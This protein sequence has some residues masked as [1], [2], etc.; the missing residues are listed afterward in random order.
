MVIRA[1]ITKRI[2]H[3]SDNNFSIYKVSLENGEEHVIT[4]YFPTLSEDLLYEFE[5]EEV[6]HP[7]FGLQY[8]ASK[9]K[10]ATEQNKV[11][12]ISYLSS[13]LFFG[14]GVVTATKIVNHLGDDAI[15]KILENKNVLREIGLN[16]LQTE[17]FYQALYENQTNE[18]ILVELYSYGLTT[19]LAMRLLNFYGYDVI[20]IIKENPYVLIEDIESIGFL[21]AD[22]IAFKLGFKENDQR[23]IEAAIIFSIKQYID[24]SGH[25]YLYENHLYKAIS[26][27]LNIN[28]LEKEIQDAIN[29]LIKNELI[30]KENNTYTLFEIKAIEENLAKY[31]LTFTK[32]ESTNINIDSLIETVEQT[33]YVDYT[34]QQKQAIIEAVNNPITVIT[35]GPGTGKTTVLLG[36]LR[37]YGLLNGLNLNSESIIETIG[38]CAPTGR[39]ARRMSEITGM[40]AFTIHRL[41]GYDYDKKFQYDEKN[42]LTQQLFI[43][44]EA[45]MIDIFLAEQLFKA[46]PEGA[47]VVIVGD[48]DQLPSVGPGHVLGDIIESG[49]VPVIVLDEIHRQSLN[50]GIISLANDVNMQV[51]T[52]MTLAKEEDLVYQ[53]LNQNEIIGELIKITDQSLKEGFSLIEDTQVL[54]PMY[55]GAVGI[56]AVNAAFQQHLRSNQTVFMQR[57]RE[58]YYIN[59]KVMHLVNSPD[60]GVMNGDIGEIINI[61][62]TTDDK[63]VLIVQYDDAEVI[64]S[65]AELEE[66]TLAY[67]I[68]IHKSQGSEYKQVLMPLVIG[69]K[70][71]LRKELLY[72]GITRAKENLH[73]LGDLSLIEYASRKL[74][75]KRLTRLKTYLNQNIEENQES[76]EV[77]PFDFM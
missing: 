55:K 69:Y 40:K 7:R 15:R 22:Q 75:E 16:S 21:R 46:I 47:K 26:R 13:D 1:Y 68:S 65:P 9:Y 19:N 51:A 72:T 77:S 63:E 39:A 23:R 44:D 28:R 43:I 10:Q 20:E 67:A 32:A 52:Q 29:S 59:D 11:G 53:E 76:I 38:V 45:S 12:L 57:G 48:K 60:K 18:K 24:K 4:G 58:R 73:I 14:V 31:L 35:G 42:Q 41:L 3:N 71:M 8:K 49:T 37:V 25:T 33:V 30:Y 74:N 50:S 62:K 34:K 61:Y 64:Y 6:V 70:I 56:D 5:V 66:L 17:R 27:I 2:F 54:I 36:L